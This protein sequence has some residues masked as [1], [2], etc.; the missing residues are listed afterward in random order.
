MAHDTLSAARADMAATFDR[1]ATTRQIKGAADRSYRG[2]SDTI[3][4]RPLAALGAAAGVG[5]L[6]GVVLNA[7]R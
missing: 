5:L 6:I 2:L 4:E 7:M 3:A 1:H